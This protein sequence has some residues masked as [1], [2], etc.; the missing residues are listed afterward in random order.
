MKFSFRPYCCSLMIVLMILGFM[1]PQSLVAQQKQVTATELRDAVKQSAAVR[2]GNLEQV[3]SFF[4]DPKVTKILKDA[5]LDSVRID[6]A[7]S[8][9]DASEL[10]KLAARTSQ[11]QSDF[12]AGSLTNQELTYIVIAIGA[13]VIVLILVS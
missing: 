5:H 2:Q 11:V 9:L 8:T 13:A 3:R 7:M 6:K 12:A 4:A 10:S 1:V